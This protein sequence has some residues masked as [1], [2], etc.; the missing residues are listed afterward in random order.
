ML[1]NSV[2]PAAGSQTWNVPGTYDFLVPPGVYRLLCALWGGG[3]AGGLGNNIGTG[4]SGAAFTLG[5]IDVI[6]G[7]H[8]SLTVGAGGK[9]TGANGGDTTVG[10][11]LVAHGGR[12]GYIDGGGP[13]TN[14]GGTATAYVAGSGQLLSVPGGGS[15]DAT[16]AGGG[17]AAGPSGAGGNGS[18]GGG[19]AGSASSGDI[20]AG[21]AGARSSTGAAVDGTAPG[22]GGSCGDYQS[23]KSGN[24]A[25]GQATIWW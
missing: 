11:G 23:G 4:G 1:L 13:S 15:V 24:G 20:P 8:V 12:G 18:G 6:P 10:S 5:F 7:Q 22:G 2:K 19:G 16:Y 14:P 25:S 3:G 21:G 17:G 9:G